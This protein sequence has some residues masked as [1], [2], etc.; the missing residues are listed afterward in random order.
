MDSNRISY[1]GTNER[2]QKEITSHPLLTRNMNVYLQKA[3]FIRAKIEFGHQCQEY[4]SYNLDIIVVN[5]A[6]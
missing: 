1:Q 5:R 6:S 2:G 4:G 3:E